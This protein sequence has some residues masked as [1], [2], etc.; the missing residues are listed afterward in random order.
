KSRKGVFDLINKAFARMT[1]SESIAADN[2]KKMATTPEMCR[3]VSMGYACGD[4]PV[5]SI[6]FDKKVTEVEI[7][8]LFWSLAKNCRGPVCG[9]NILGF[10]LPVIF[11][12]SILL[13]IKP[14]RGF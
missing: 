2:C 14:T 8:G 12:R 7:L 9:Y 6:T 13:G 1:E 11:A 5:Q 3:I 10:D 4:G